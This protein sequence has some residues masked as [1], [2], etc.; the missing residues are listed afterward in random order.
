MREDEML[1][2]QAVGQTGNVSPPTHP[3]APT[4]SSSSMDASF[5]GPEVLSL[6]LLPPD[7]RGLWKSGPSFKTRQ[8]EALPSCVHHKTTW[9]A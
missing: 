6:C 9:E 3:P 8:E 4:Q 5:S 2:W 1:T 7:N